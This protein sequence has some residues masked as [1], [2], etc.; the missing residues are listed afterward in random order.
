[1]QVN[2]LVVF[3]QH[4]WWLMVAKNNLPWYFLNHHDRATSLIDAFWVILSGW[5]LVVFFFS[6]FSP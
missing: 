4:V 1:M 5:V 3:R 2:R 6:L